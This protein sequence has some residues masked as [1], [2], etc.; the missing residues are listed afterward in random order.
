MGSDTRGNMHEFP[1]NFH[2]KAYYVCLRQINFILNCVLLSH[3]RTA[4]TF[5]ELQRP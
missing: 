3:H 4:T 1:S 2:N 5:F